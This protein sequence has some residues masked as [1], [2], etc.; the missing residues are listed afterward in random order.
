MTRRDK[1][2]MACDLSRDP[3]GSAQ[4][5]ASVVR[6]RLDEHLVEQSGFDDGPV[7][8]GV[9]G[10][11]AR[12]AQRPARREP[13]R[14]GHVLHDELLGQP[15]HGEGEVAVAVLDRPAG[16]ARC[17]ERFYQ[18]GAEQDPALAGAAMVI[19]VGE[20]QAQP[21]GCIVEG[22]QVAEPCEKSRATVGRESHDL[23]LVALGTKAEVPGHHA[24]E[25]ADRVRVEHGVPAGEPAVPALEDAGCLV[26]APAIECHHGGL[27]E[28]RC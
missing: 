18:A 25:V 20:I 4:A 21:S 7:R 14:E 28:R 12:H 6:G 16:L 27:V 17:P 24:V 2:W 15:L 11:A 13:A 1:G 5:S 22:G 8:D 26:L 3:E 9:E 19:E 10:D 23:V